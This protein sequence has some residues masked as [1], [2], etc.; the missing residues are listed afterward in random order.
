MKILFLSCHSVLEKMEVFC[1]HKPLVLIIGTPGEEFMYFLV[2]GF[3]RTQVEDNDYAW[4]DVEKG[5]SV[6][7]N[8]CPILKK[9]GIHYKNLT[10][11]LVRDEA[12]Y[13]AKEARFEGE[14]PFIRDRI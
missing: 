14:E 5:F 1:K 2:D 13:R 10:H 8:R 11:L 3:V 9:W 6:V 7:F 12:V 4:E